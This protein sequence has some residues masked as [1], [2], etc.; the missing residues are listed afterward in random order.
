M[1]SYRIPARLAHV[2]PEDQPDSST[3]VFLMQL[4][5]GFPVRLQDSGAWI[6]LLAADG[7]DDVAGAVG[8]LVGLPRG[9]VE[10]DVNAFLE[11]LVQHRLLD[12]DIRPAEPHPEPG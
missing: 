7:E 12:V 8:E 6:W 5:D 4:P 9:A 1:T 10:D 2:V 3:A 11:S